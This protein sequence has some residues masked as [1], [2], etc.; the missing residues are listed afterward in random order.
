MATGGSSQERTVIHSTNRAILLAGVCPFGLSE[1]MS[2]IPA[3]RSETRNLTSAGKAVNRLCVTL[4]SARKEI[5]L[6]R[7]FENPQLGAS[8]A[9][10]SNMLENTGLIS[11]TGTTKEKQ[12]W[13]QAFRR[14]RIRCGS[15]C[16]GLGK[17]SFRTTKMPSFSADDVGFFL[18]RHSN[19]RKTKHP[20]HRRRGR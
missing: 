20:P 11:F 12:A 4:H 18:K 17:S 7:L 5:A 2:A 6:Q 16:R 15:A 14:C 8:L 13:V 1:L 3:A 19:F 10:V 9:S